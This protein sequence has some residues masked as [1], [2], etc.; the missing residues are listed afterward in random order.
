MK[1]PLVRRENGA[2]KKS[3]D[4]MDRQIRNKNRRLAE[5]AQKTASHEQ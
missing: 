4:L 2:K 5:L 3:A 1:E